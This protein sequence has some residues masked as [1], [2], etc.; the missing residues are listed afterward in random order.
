MTS[1]LTQQA[2]TDLG[3]R[4]RKIVRE[5]GN[6]IEAI[7]ADVATAQA[8]ITTNANNISDNDTDIA[9][10]QSQQS[11]NTSNIS[12]NASDIAILQAQI[13][14][15]FGGFYFTTTSVTTI[16]SSGV[17]VK[18][19]G[20][21]TITN[22]SS[23][24]DDNS[25]S[26]RMRYTGTSMRHFHVVAQASV[27]LTLGTNQDIGIQVWRYDDSAAAG[28]L[29]AHSEAHTTIP[30]TSVVQITTH[31]DAML[32]TDDYLELHVANHTN[33]NNV[34]VQYGY[35]FMMGMPV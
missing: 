11:T 7:Q 6:E 35:M 2:P 34:M 28:A 29:L 1:I 24:V 12:T 27:D 19:A 4:T 25:V 5:V 33:S 9:A 13:I 32:D 21:T 17:Y 23:D 15:P 8:D 31:A 30:G 26:N 22:Q 16:N 18:A 3:P 14:F 20:T 10:L